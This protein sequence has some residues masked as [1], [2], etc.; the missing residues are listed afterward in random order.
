[1]L[2]SCG[3]PPNNKDECVGKRF[4]RIS[5]TLL[6]FDKKKLLAEAS[7]FKMQIQDESATGL[8]AGLAF[9]CRLFKPRSG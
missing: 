5:E 2:L 4:G 9:F 1:M 6:H 8:A 7:N 3:V